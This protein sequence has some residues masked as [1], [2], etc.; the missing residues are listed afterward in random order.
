MEAII[1]Y[2][3]ESSIIFLVLFLVYHFSFAPYKNFNFNRVFLLIS[4]AFALLIPIVD[5]PFI[6]SNSSGNS[7]NLQQMIMLPEVIIRET[8]CN[9]AATQTEGWSVAN[10]MLVVYFTGLGLLLTRFL[11]RLGQMMLFIVRHRHQ[12]EDRGK[13]YYLPT[14]GQISTCSFFKYLLWDETQPLNASQQRQ[15]I[16]HETTHIQNGHSYDVL[17]IE[18]LCI[19]FWFNPVIYFYKG[20]LTALHEYIADHKAAQTSGLQNYI[21]LL[22]Y[23]TLHAM[24]LALGNHFFQTQIF[25]R[26]KMLKNQK[27]RSWL[28]RMLLATSVFA[29]LFYVFACETET[30]PSDNVFTVDGFDEPYSIVSLEDSPDKIKAM[31]REIS[32]KISAE[33]TEIVRLNNDDLSKLMETEN[34]KVWFF[35]SVGEEAQSMYAITEKIPGYSHQEEL[36]KPHY[37]ENGEKVYHVV[38]K[39]PE[40]KND[41]ASFYQFIAQ[42]IK[43]PKE[44]RA[45]GIQGKVFVQFVVNENGVLEQIKAVRG[46]NEAID[47]EAV[48]VL[49]NAPKWEPGYLEGE[50][51]KV[52]MVLPI[53]FKLDSPEEKNESSKPKKSKSTPGP[54]SAAKESKDDAMNEMVVVG[55]QN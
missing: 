3:L 18:M 24:Q 40:P 53:T 19:V 2:Y 46:I 10:V 43:Y 39:R 33:H 42:N 32:D 44:A 31:H 34:Y 26:M 47:A 38:D 4:A 13:Y 22:S 49:S 8:S 36:K 50:P 37:D 54:T 9:I 35:Y 30:A 11:V 27:S 28:S 17:I 52:R 6:T 16:I 29:L 45:K 25:N 51:V 5:L 7:N 21:K 20:A 23:Q 1:S 14:G 48:R 15:V 55:Y 41:M 12:I